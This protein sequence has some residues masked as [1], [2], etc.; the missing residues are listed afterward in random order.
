MAPAFLFW[1]DLV[2]ENGDAEV[3]DKQHIETL[4]EK[5]LVELGYEPVI[6][7]W[8]GSSHRPIIRLR[9]DNIQGEASNLGVTVADCARASRH[10]EDWLEQ[11]EVFPETYVLEVSSPGVNRPLVKPSDWE[12]FVGQSVVVQTNTKI[13]VQGEKSHFEGKLLGVDGKED[14]SPSAQMQLKDGTKLK[15]ELSKVKKANLLYDW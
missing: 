15:F 9:I 6:I 13:Q 7:Q 14:S 12:R 11:E 8:A 1:E 2:L 4:I 5:E 10:L 3:L